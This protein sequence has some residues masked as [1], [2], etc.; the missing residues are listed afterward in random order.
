M[1]IYLHLIAA[2]ML[3]AAGWCVRGWRDDARMARVLGSAQVAAERQRRVDEAQASSLAQRLDATEAAYEAQE[4][5]I[6]GET[7][8]Q[9]SIQACSNKSIF[10]AEFVGLWNRDPS[11]ISGAQ[12]AH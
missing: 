8:V 12:Q 10:S 1:K 2:L 7:L 11:E 4:K 3:L 5:R 9:S 6:S